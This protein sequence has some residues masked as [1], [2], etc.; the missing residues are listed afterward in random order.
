MWLKAARVVTTHPTPELVPVTGEGFFLEPVQHSDF[1]FYYFDDMYGNMYGNQA[2]GAAG[3]QAAAAS[4]APAA[5]KGSEK[6]ETRFLRMLSSAGVEEV[7]IDAFGDSG[8]TTLAGFRFLAKDEDRLRALLKKDPIKL[9]EDNS[10][11]EAVQV[12]NIISVYESA[13]E[14]IAVENKHKAER[15]YQ[16]LPPKLNVGELEGLKKLFEKAEYELNPIQ[17]PSDAYFERKTHELETRYVAEALTRVTNSKQQ[18]VND[19]LTCLTSAFWQ[20][21]FCKYEPVGLETCYVAVQ[22]EMIGIT[23]IFVRSQ[24]A[25]THLFS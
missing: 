25:L 6:L 24:L 3:A 22:N 1:A 23:A 19:I 20:Y 2:L 17:I 5:K 13:K 12:S 11:A 14:T 18:D 9:D 21:L 8:I 4:G 10:I 16:D 15:L 7:T